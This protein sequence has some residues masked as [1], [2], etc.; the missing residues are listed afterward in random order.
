MRPNVGWVIIITLLFLAGTAAAG[1]ASVINAPNP[2]WVIANGVDQTTI[3]V[4]VQNT[5]TGPVNG[6]TVTFAVNDSIYGTLSPLTVTTGPSGLATSIVKVNKKSGTANITALISYNDG[7]GSVNV[8]KNVLLHIDHDSPYIVT[9]THPFTGTV[10]T[11]VPFNLSMTDRHGN[12]ID[13]RK[14]VA[15]GLPLHALSLHVHGPSPDDCV[16]NSSFWYKHDITETLD[17]DGNLSVN[18][19][20]T[21]KIGTNSILMDQFG[22][23][24]EKIESITAVATGNPYSMTGSISHG[25]S[26]PANGIDFFTLDY[27]LYDVYGNPLGNRS[28]WVNTTLPNEQQFFTT[29]TLGEI[30]LSYGPKTAVWN[31]I[32]IT[33]ISVDNHTVTNELFASF[34]DTGPTNM[35][36]AVTPQTMASLEVA[37]SQNAI[38][39]ATVIDLFGNPVPNEMVR[40]DITGINNNGFNVSAVNGTP[41]F[42]STSSLNT[43]TATTDADGNAIV[44]F[45]PGSFPKQTEPGYN[46]FANASCTI[47]ATWSSVTRDI[48]VTWKNYPYLS[49]EASASPQNLHVNDTVDVTIRVIGDGWA[50][51]PNLIDVVLCT[52]RSGSMMYDNPDRM[53]NIMEAAATFV[54]QMGTNDQIGAVS[55]GQKGTAQAITYTPSGGGQLGPGRDSST[56]DDVAYRAA[57]YPASPKNYADYATVDFGLS[58]NKAQVKTNINSMIPYSGTPMRS[59]LYKS[60]Q[61]IN[62]HKRSD[63]V[64]AIIL[65]TDGDYNWYGDPLAR[66]TGSSSSGAESYSDLDLD[67]MAFTGLGSGKFSNQNM[68]IYAKNNGIRIYSIA[69]G[70]LIS[71]EGKKTLSILANGTGGKYYTASATDITDVYTAIAGDLKDTAGVNATMNLNYQNVEVNS[72]PMSGGLVFDYVPVENGPTS[73]DSRTTILW[74][75]NTRSFRNQSGEWTPANNYQLHFDIGTIKI[76]ER[77]ETIYRFKANQTG[78]VRLFDN[79]SIISFNNGADRVEFPDLFITVT[80]NLTV[81]G[82]HAG[83]LD[84]SNLNVTKSGNYTDFI[85][86]QWNLHY[87]GKTTATETRWYSHNNGPWI[88]FGTQSGISPGDYTHY[89]QLDVKKFPPGGYQIKIFGVAPDARE[90]EEVTS[91]IT[92]GSTGIFIKLE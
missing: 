33:A 80:P 13:N 76:G 78:L 31:N 49:I 88:Q 40:F 62:L 53:V 84:V 26:I 19:K 83:I 9:F 42:S 51:Q 3:T 58:F 68:S 86:L 69:F 59:A 47:H 74:P 32:R 22:S 4:T 25:G 30:L 39:R 79:T 52:D 41:S 54:D 46:M 23:I 14:E 63:T 11:E 12:P 44:L 66:G 75:N 67:Y 77:W 50:F 70:N 60:I 34:I 73:P 90:D 65:L 72:T 35:V 89:A 36:L 27:F 24:S 82:T 37:P 91:A 71:A 7:G 1:D 85:P 29:N 2:D 5:T 45:Y 6:A 20:L 87:E 15:S 92:V 28:V 57:H 61:E 43:I 17:A 16:F 48:I 64:K 56:S 18:V 8:Q 21:S 10:A 55:F 81:V 38:V